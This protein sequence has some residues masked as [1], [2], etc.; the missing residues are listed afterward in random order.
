MALSLS[1][2]SGATRSWVRAEHLSLGALGTFRE[3]VNS[4]HVPA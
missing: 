3:Y 4:A 1:E 2:M